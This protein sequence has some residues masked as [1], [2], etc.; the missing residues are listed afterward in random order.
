MTSTGIHH[1]ELETIKWALRDVRGGDCLQ[2]PLSNAV[3]IMDEEKRFRI[4]TVDGNSAAHK[5]SVHGQIANHG[6]SG[7]VEII[8]GP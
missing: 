2:P 1:L 7:I 8:G 5:R 6:R 4:M 3:V